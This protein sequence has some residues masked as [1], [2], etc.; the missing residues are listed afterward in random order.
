MAVAGANEDDIVVNYHSVCLYRSDL[1]LFR[2]PKWLNDACLG[3][4]LECVTR[5]RIPP[6]T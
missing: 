4:V 6:P 3:F 5:P 2:P 1:A